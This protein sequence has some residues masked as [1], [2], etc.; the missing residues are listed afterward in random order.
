MKVGKLTDEHIRQIIEENDLREVAA[1]YGVEFNESG[2][3]TCPFHRDGKNGNLHLFEKK[4]EDPTYFCFSRKCS[5]GR[6]WNDKEKTSPN[7][8]TLPDGQEVEDGGPNVIGFVMNI[9]RCSFIEACITL[10]DRAGIEP[11]KAKENYK[12]ERLKSKTHKRNIGYCQNLLST[13]HM[14]DYLKERGIHKESIKK[15]RLGYIKPTDKSNP[16]FG[17]K[18]SGRLVFGLAGEGF[19]AK[20]AKTVAMAYRTMKDEKPKYINDYNSSIYEKRHYLYGINEARKA[21]RRMGYA[22]VTEGYTD[23]IIA[24]QA[25]LENTVATCGTAFTREQMEKL[26][27]LTS[28]LVFWYDGDSA[29]YDA[30]LESIEELLEMGF[31]VKIVTAPGYDP[32]EVMNKLGQ[33]AE[34]I[35]KFIAD[36]ARP[37]LQVIAE[38]SLSEY[39]TKVNAM[40]T[41][42]LDEL[43]PVL[44]SITDEAEKITFKSMIAQRLG[45]VL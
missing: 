42:A 22:M 15:W 26:R 19:D 40:K 13:K 11:P 39:E 27:K 16:L 43:L 35:K 9:E 23:V 45:V 18:V 41:E 44:N 17:E 12:E 32:A 34:A 20:K 30:M 29:G 33:K 4:D 1:E 14:L 24:H 2:K 37:A 21:I 3:A 8:L 36:K 7:I 28:N 25:G 5:A 38:E 6:K 31:R 10:M